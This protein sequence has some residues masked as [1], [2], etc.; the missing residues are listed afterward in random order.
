MP[1]NPDYRP[2]PEPFAVFG[3][4]KLI[5]TGDRSYHLVGGSDT[6]RAEAAEWCALYMKNDI[7]QGLPCGE[8]NL[9]PA[10]RIP[11]RIRRRFTTVGF[12][13]PLLCRVNDQLP[14]RPDPGDSEWLRTLSLSSH[15]NYHGPAG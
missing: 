6:D 7:V 11:P 1:R 13:G 3:D 2:E 4:A 10:G 9:S 12:V 15:V 5:R 14:P 8:F